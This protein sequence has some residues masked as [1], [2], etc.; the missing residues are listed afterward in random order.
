MFININLAKEP[1]EEH[2]QEEGCGVLIII[3][4]TTC[5]IGVLKGGGYT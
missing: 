5:M 2:G 3:M 4:E 1:H